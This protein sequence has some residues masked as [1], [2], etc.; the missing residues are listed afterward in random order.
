MSGAA[1]NAQVHG[2]DYQGNLSPRNITPTFDH[3][4]LIVY[5]WDRRIDVFSPDGALMYSVAAQ[6]PGSDWADIE[7]GAVDEDGTLAAAVRA[8][9]EPGHARAGGIALFDRTGRQIGFFDTGEYLP[10]QAAFGPDHSIWTLGWL[11]G[12]TRTSLTA[13]YRVLR[14]YAQDGRQL[15][16]FLPRALF[17]YPEY[18]GREP[19]I[20]PM[21]GLWELRVANERVEAVLH[22]PRL[23][24]ETGLNG[25]EMGRWDIVPN[26]RPSAVTKDGRAWQKQGSQL[27]LFNRSTGVWRAVAFECSRGHS[28]GR[29]GQQ[30]S[31]PAAK[32]KYA[33][34]GDCPRR[35]SDALNYWGRGGA[36]SK[37]TDVP[38]ARVVV[39]RSL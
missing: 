2:V 18:L 39:A 10:T 3:G 26:G 5:D 11:G 4:Y 17:P 38:R 20:M 12:A 36:V 15:G 9:S 19:L 16:A 13:H 32:S 31:V 23:W 1:A 33:A 24:V 34:M 35:V 27:Q 37:T 21:L 14:E 7:S 25:Q 22:R 29:R 28:A 6:A 30:P 8:V